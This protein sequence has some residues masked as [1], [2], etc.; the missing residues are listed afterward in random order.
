MAQSRRAIDTVSLVSWGFLAVCASPAHA[1]GP[2]AS[3]AI[4]DGLNSVH[5]F[6]EVALS[7][8]GKRVVY[9]NVVTGKRSGADV[10]VSALWIVDARDGSGRD[11]ADGLPRLDLRRAWRQLV[12][13]RQTYR[14]RNHRSRMISRRSSWRT[15]GAAN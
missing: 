1:A 13:R 2:P 6:A 10:D 12:C 11:A 3:A 8:D 4:L 5:P 7:P 9:G 14:L 15:R